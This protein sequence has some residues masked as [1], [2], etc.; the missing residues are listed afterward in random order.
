MIIKIVK[1]I[2]LDGGMFSIVRVR[3]S[4]KEIYPLIAFFG[5]SGE[6]EHYGNFRNPE[7]A[8]NYLRNLLK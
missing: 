8:E 5:S 7:E 2:C 1:N 4:G 6:F 3:A